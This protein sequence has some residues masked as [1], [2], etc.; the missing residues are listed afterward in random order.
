MSAL[1]EVIITL[2]A[3][4]P[5]VE[6]DDRF[7]EEPPI[8]AKQARAELARI[9]SVVDA[10]GEWMDGGFDIDL[11]RAYDAWKQATTAAPAWDASIKAD[12]P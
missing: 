11:E 8:L 5:L 3:L 6:G 10:V 9:K 12:Q 7:Y 2:E 1:D 4:V